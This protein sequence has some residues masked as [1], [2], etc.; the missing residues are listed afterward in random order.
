MRL[1][2]RT[3]LAYMDQVLDEQTASEIAEKVQQS[4]VASEI[5]QR[6]EDVLRRPRLGAPELS[7]R[8]MQ[9]DPN[10]V[11]EYL[12]NVLSKEQVADFEKSCLES[13]TLLAEVASCHRVLANIL[14]QPIEVPA[15]CR[16]KL[17]ELVHRRREL[18]AR[19]AK[20]SGE[21]P[22]PRA[23]G[24]DSSAPGQSAPEE[25]LLAPPPP[26]ETNWRW[27][28]AAVLA[29]VLVVSTLM[30]VS[31]RGL[32]NS[33]SEE[34]ARNAPPQ[35]TPPSGEKDKP[36]KP[37]VA[38]LPAG[39]PAG[40]PDQ[41]AAQKPPEAKP[42]RPQSSEPQAPPKPSTEQP[43]QKTPPLPKGSGDSSPPKPSGTE[44]SPLPK[45]PAGN[46]Q[47]VRPLP[48][49]EK[50]VK[51]LP[52]PPEKSAPQPPAAVAKLTS[53]GTLLYRPRG[54]E[55]WDWVHQYLTPLQGG[56]RLVV[57]YGFSASVVAT[58]GVQLQLFSQT[59]VQLP[60]S[61]PSAKEP[62]AVRRGRL[63]VLTPGR[64]LVRLPFRWGTLSGQV[65]LVSPG[66][67]MACQLRYQRALGTD[68]L[69]QPSELVVTLFCIAGT[70][71]W[72]GSQGEVLEV[73][74]N[75]QILLHSG[76]PAQAQPQATPPEWL[77][78]DELPQLIR[79]ATPEL[80][81]LFHQE[82]DQ[83]S[84]KDVELLLREIAQQHRQV[85]VSYLALVHLM[86]LGQFDPVVDALREPRFRKG[87][88]W[89]KLLD[90]LYRAAAV[91]PE[92]AAR[93]QQAFVQRR[94]EQVGNQL[95]LL[96]RGFSR[97]ELA[98]EPVANQAV[99]LLAHGDLD[100]RRIVF[101]NLKRALGVHS[102]IYQPH[103]YPPS[104]RAL[105]EWRNRLQRL[106]KQ[107]AR[108]KK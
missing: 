38:K 56:D 87:N 83:Q 11:A 55:N 14:D 41:A 94:G 84:D 2:L 10:T 17:Y 108:V 32:W 49:P 62:L 80:L 92:V 93:V 64:Q 77:H 6:I 18:A 27:L 48:A 1:T 71:R 75:G 4:E 69:K 30:S 37:D 47:P 59:Q 63:V 79:E 16:K 54:G 89:E 53:R 20:E 22:P 57:P 86:D 31:P 74:Q 50:P 19:E 40:E 91:S 7:G 15:E 82:L 97:E 76:R 105:H 52:P 46:T 78:R 107:S 3:L 68:L 5:L 99:A 67:A 66:A 72:R 34:V 25:D 42:P 100:F 24:E 26:R 44:S 96:L 95:F 9:V 21:K 104:N 13:N 106:R 36:Q 85:E 58:D 33:S 103:A 39:Q 73:G 23:S 102:S 8:G 70:L 88:Y 60:S 98:Q 12:D 81:R 90:H 43:S 61:W 35:P 29:V 28:I 51:P 65:E 45:P 101:W